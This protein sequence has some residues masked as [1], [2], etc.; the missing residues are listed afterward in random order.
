MDPS[1]PA[2]GLAA[3]LEEEIRGATLPQHPFWLSSREG[4]LHA[5]ALASDHLSQGQ[6]RLSQEILHRGAQS[7]GGQEG[8]GMQRPSP[9]LMLLPHRPGC[10]WAVGHCKNHCLALV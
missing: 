9:T 6:E 10:F 7:Q 8:L 5:A 4:S 3:S 1:L 2:I